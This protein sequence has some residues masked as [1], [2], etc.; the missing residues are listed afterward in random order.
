[1][2]KHTPTPWYIESVAVNAFKS[3]VS[4]VS[5][6]GGKITNINCSDADAAFIVRAVNAHDA[7]VEAID[8]LL[9][10]A[11]PEGMAIAVHKAREALK[12]AGAV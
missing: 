10:A 9:T 1:M 7:L 4:L 6:T 12:L 8:Y 11:E 3:A 5:E 2:T